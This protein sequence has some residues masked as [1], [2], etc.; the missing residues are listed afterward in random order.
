MTFTRASLRNHVHTPVVL[1]CK[2]ETKLFAALPKAV[3][4]NL[5]LIF[6]LQ[7]QTYC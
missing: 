6:L 3:L 7:Y 2:V 1:S 5:L 4:L